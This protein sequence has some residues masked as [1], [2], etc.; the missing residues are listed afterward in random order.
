MSRK[1]SEL[2]HTYEYTNEENGYLVIEE[3]Y[4]YIDEKGNEVITGTFKEEKNPNPVIEESIPE[5]SQ[6]D[7]IE[8][9]VSKSAEELRQ[10]GAEALTLELIE[11]GIL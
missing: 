4:G 11:G 10:E 1:K 8:E 9:M 2:L 7:R 6:L 3:I 5:P